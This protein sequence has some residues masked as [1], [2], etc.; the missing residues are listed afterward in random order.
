MTETLINPPAPDT[1]NLAE[2]ERYTVVKALRL[3][4]TISDAAKLLGLT[5]HAT[6]RRMLRYGL[7]FF[8]GTVSIG[9]NELVI[10]SD[11][12]HMHTPPPEPVSL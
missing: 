7:T 2:L 11:E 9:A 5:R 12:Q 8:K 6:K 3:S 10:D 1:L 4:V